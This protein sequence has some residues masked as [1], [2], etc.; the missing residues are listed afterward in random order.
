MEHTVITYEGKTTTYQKKEKCLCMTESNS[1]K[2]E[3]NPAL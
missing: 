2:A 1:R 3:T